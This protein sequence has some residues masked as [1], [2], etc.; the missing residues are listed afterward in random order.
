MGAVAK[1]YTR[2]RATVLQRVAEGKSLKEAIKGTT[3][4]D[5]GT[6]SR[7]VRDYF[8]EVQERRTAYLAQIEQSE[9]VDLRHRAKVLA[10]AVAATKLEGEDYVPDHK[11]RLETVKYIDR[12]GKLVEGDEEKTINAIQI[13]IAG[14]DSKSWESWT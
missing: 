2:T 8:H 10:E 11:I 13:N 6:A 12:L 14:V 5:R 7:W 9:G 4:K 3:V 1:R